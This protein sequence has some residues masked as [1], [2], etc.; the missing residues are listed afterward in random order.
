MDYQETLARVPL[1]SMMKKRELNNIADMAE[2]LLYEPGEMIIREGDS[3]GRLFV[4]LEGQV[5]VV[6]NLG[7]ANWRNL[8][9][10]GQGSYFGEMAVLGTSRRT[11]S[12][13]AVEQAKLMCL[14][15]FNLRAAMEKHPN[16]AI[17]LLQTL[18]ARLEEKEQRLLSELGGLLPICSHC[19][20]I[21]QADGSWLAVEAYVHGHSEA[22]FSHGICPECRDKHYPGI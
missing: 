6:K 14:A 16:I 10:L 13:V 15:D 21:R 18:A 22:D 11:A 17:E 7:Q 19:K 3:D 8:N 5:E 20:R 12:V 1:F 4:I 9:R 2:V